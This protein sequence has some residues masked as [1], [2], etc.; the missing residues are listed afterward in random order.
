MVTTPINQVTSNVPVAP[1]LLGQTSQ[2]Y[3]DTSN[4]QTRVITGLNG[5]KSSVI[6]ILVSEK[7]ISAQ[8]VRDVISRVDNISK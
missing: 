7:D 6:I 3:K 2:A 5:D 8:M 4:S 1:P